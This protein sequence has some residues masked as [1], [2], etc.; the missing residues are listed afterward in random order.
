VEML[1]QM[2]GDPNSRDSN[3]CT[4]LTVACMREAWS[5][6]SLLM[7]AGADLSIP[8][9]CPGGGSSGSGSGGSMKE[10]K[11]WR[12]PH[13]LLTST[14]VRKMLYARISAP[15]TV[16]PLDQRDRCMHCALSFVGNDQDGDGGSDVGDDADRENV[17]K[18]AKT[19][20]NNATSLTSMMASSFL[21]S[22]TSSSLS[23]ASFSLSSF[24]ADEKV[25]AK[26]HCSLCVRV[27]CETC[28]SYR[29]PRPM[30]PVFL[31]QQ[32]STTKIFT[33]CAIC[34]AILKEKKSNISR[35]R[36]AAKNHLGP[37]IANSYTVIDDNHCHS[38]PAPRDN[39]IQI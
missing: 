7:G 28:A 10:M 5:I 20:N 27:V 16:I 22:F 6:C 11:K 21:S 14:A 34:Y 26:S 19:P 18:S 25:P 36:S 32:F 33:V 3:G 23:S 39:H 4:P 13:D 30:M 35:N 2:G 31:Q 24:S 1:L 17:E 15:Q 29:V 38:I 8:F 9:N 37:L 12:R